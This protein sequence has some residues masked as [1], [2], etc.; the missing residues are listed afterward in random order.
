MPTLPS[1]PIDRCR[2]STPVVGD[3]HRLVG[4][5]THAWPDERAARP[6]GPPPICDYCGAMRCGGDCT[7]YYDA[8]ADDTDARYETWRDGEVE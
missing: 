2:R 6:D 5:T 1:V 8:L 3:P 4:A 7:P